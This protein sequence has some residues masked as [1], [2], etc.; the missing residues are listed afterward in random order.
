MFKTFE[1]RNF[2][3]IT[4]L[5]S[6][7]CFETLMSEGEVFGDATLGENQEFEKAYLW[8]KTQANERIPI[9]EHSKARDLLWGF[10]RF[11]NHPS[12]LSP[13][14]LHCFRGI[15]IKIDVLV[16]VMECLLSDYDLWHCVLLDT[17]IVKV[18]EISKEISWESIFD[19]LSFG[20][21][22]QAVFWRLKKEWIIGW[23]RMV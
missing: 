19:E 18:S 22:V 13:Q 12:P 21:S 23:S 20:P 5:Q 15:D 16:P 17:P 10:S 2:I 8:M 6:E 9:R 11:E 1:Q 14:Q 7:Q 3:P 4:T